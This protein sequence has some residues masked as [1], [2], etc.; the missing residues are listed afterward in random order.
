[1][2]ADPDNNDYHI[3]FS[4]AA[5]NAGV[6]AGVNHDIDNQLRPLEGTPDIGADEYNPAYTIYFPITPGK[7]T[8]PS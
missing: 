4:S 2:F 6:D 5:H 1:M 7:P 8:P 3:T